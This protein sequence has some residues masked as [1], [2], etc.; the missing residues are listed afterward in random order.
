MALDNT[1][2]W[3][4]T[5]FIVTWC[6]LKLFILHLTL[7]AYYVV[8]LPGLRPKALKWNDVCQRLIDRMNTFK[9]NFKMYTLKGSCGIFKPSPYSYMFWCVNHAYFTN[10]RDPVD[11]LNGQDRYSCNWCI[12]ATHITETIPIGLTV[13][14]K[15]K[16]LLVTR[17][18]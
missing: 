14:L 7:K 13:L 12:G 4:P 9:C 10:N 8:Y 18:I 5:C 1:T 6:L 11:R 3:L 2:L 16:I 15:R 17:L